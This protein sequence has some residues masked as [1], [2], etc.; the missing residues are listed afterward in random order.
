MNRQDKKRLARSGKPLIKLHVLGAAGGVTGSL[1]LIEYTEKGVV[2]RFLLDAGLTVE[3]ESADFKNRLPSGLQAQDIDFI[4]I[5][6]AHIDHSGLLPKLVKDGFK[7]RAYVTEAT[8]ELLEI[9]LP[10]SGYLQEENARR[11]NNRAVKFKAIV[12]A[13]GTAATKAQ[14][15]SAA[16]SK[17][18]QQPLYTRQ[19]ATNALDYLSVLPYNERIE[20]APGVAVTLTDAGHLLGSAVVNLEISTGSEKRRFCFTGNLGR[21][22]MPILKSAAPLLPADYLMTEATYGNK[23]HKQRDRLEVLAGIVNGAYERAKAKN[24]VILIPA[25][26]VGRAQT[27]LFD[28]RQLMISGRIPRMPVFVDGPMANRSTA[29]HRK[30]SELF[31]EKTAKLL[32][33]GIDPFRTPRYTE[34]VDRVDSELLDKPM[35]EPTIIVGSSGMANG[36]RIVRHL[37][38]RLS[39]PE[40]TVLFVGYQGTGTLGSALVGCHIDPTVACATEVKIY[41]TPV[42]VKAKL[43]FMSDY[44]GH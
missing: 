21:P 1:N 9:M 38:Q 11:A 32:D 18:S 44:S 23:T 20:L 22:D 37:M 6:H 12:T 33:A 40:N 42:Q 24:G 3:N 25:F 27:V 43:E 29:V 17:T 35:S 13:A 5:S 26:A 30:H 16:R 39:S 19:D 34:V 2:T 41:G 7:G 36:G 10:D 4:I 31:N 28:L 15:A 14:K 8:R